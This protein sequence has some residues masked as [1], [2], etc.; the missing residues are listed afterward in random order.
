MTKVGVQ[1]EIVLPLVEDD[2]LARVEAEHVGLADVEAVRIYNLGGVGDSATNCRA[3]ASLRSLSMAT[4]VTVGER[5]SGSTFLGELLLTV[6]V[7]IVFLICPSLLEA[8][9]VL[10]DVQVLAYHRGLQSPVILI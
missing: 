2:R 3:F 1:I 4:M 5:R 10:P 7:L 9:D 6:L 8:T